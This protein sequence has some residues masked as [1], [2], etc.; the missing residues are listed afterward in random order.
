MMEEY[1]SGVG[2]IDSPTEPASPTEKS[3]SIFAKSTS[4]STHSVEPGTTRSYTEYER[5]K[6]SATHSTRVYRSNEGIKLSSVEEV[7]SKEFEWNSPMKSR[8]CTGGHVSVT[9][10]SVPSSRVSTASCVSTVNPILAEYRD[11][12]SRLRTTLSQL[13]ADQG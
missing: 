13:S 7:P 3:A 2:S 6:Q 4:P 11:S 12:L 9:S 8:A 5:H 10:G 1:D